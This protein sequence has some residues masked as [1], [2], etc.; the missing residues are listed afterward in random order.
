MRGTRTGTNDILIE[1]QIWPK[2]MMGHREEFTILMATFFTQC[3]LL[4]ILGVR[5][6]TILKPQGKL[7]L[8]AKHF[9]GSAFKDFQLMERSLTS[10]TVLRITP[11]LADFFCLKI[12]A[13][14]GAIPPLFPESPPLWPRKK[15]F[16]IE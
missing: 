7:N 5:K 10:Y 14:F 1:G 4:P 16:C 15:L 2:E 9:V 6:M 12:L 8:R 11:L 3:I 13:E